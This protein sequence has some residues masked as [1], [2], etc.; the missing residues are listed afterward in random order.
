MVNG[1]A[2]MIAGV[3]FGP[4]HFVAPSFWKESGSNCYSVEVK[5]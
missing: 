4:W 5:L 1:G 2:N 3:N